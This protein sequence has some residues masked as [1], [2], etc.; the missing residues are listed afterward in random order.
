[1]LL[2]HISDIHFRAPDCVNPDLDPDRPYRTRLVQDARKR[3]EALGHVGAI[4]I[5]GDI[6]FKGDPLEY[7]VASAWLKELAEACMCSLERMF[8]IP[9]NHDV[10]RRVILGAPT[11]RNAQKAILLADQYHRERELRTQFT[12]PDTG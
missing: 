2:L 1:M 8:V 5:S 11:V 12:D 4:L 10:D 3:T 6:A 9:G 7:V